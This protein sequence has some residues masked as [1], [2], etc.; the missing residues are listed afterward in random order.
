MLQIPLQ[1][2]PQQNLQ[3]LVGQQLALH[4]PAARLVFMSARWTAADGAPA[5]RT[6]PALV[7]AYNK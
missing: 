6:K 4:L 2:Q 1:P 3:S 5:C 7:Q